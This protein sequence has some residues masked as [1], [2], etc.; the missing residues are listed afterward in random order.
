M[1]TDAAAPVLAKLILGFVHDLLCV[2]AHSLHLLGQDGL[3]TCVT[4]W[5]EVPGKK[6]ARM[7]SALGPAYR[8]THTI[9]FNVCTTSTR[10]CCADHRI[11]VL[12]GSGRLEYTKHMIR[13]RHAGQVGARPEANEII[14][15]NSHDGASSYQMLAGVFRLWPT[16]HRRN[17]VQRKTMSREG[18][19]ARGA[20]WNRGHSWDT[21]QGLSRAA[22][23]TFSKK[24]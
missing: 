15:I 24:S 21:T 20:A 3:T 6:G 23:T 22:L 18:A 14:L 16:G 11:D 5:I 2:N 8:F 9:S 13:M 12:V 1:R 4:R 10:S 17:Y 7:A 19:S